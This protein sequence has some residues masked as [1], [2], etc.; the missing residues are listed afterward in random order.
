MIIGNIVIFYGNN[1]ANT[2]EIDEDFLIAEIDGLS[3]SPSGTN[4][5]DP[6]DEILEHNLFNTLKKI[7]DWPLDPKDVG[8][9][10]PF[11]PIVAE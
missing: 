1:G 4:S 11:A 9:A 2:I 3:G 6:N 8:K 5:S 7:G 10:D